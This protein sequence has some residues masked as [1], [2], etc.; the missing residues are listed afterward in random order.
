[1]LLF[2]G[3]YCLSRRLPVRLL[4][5]VWCL[6]SFFLVYFYSSVLISFISASNKVPI[7]EKLT[8]LP[9]KPEV[10]VVT[11]YGWSAD[12]I[13]SVSE[14]FMFDHHQ[15]IYWNMLICRRRNLAFWSIWET[16]WI[17]TLHY[18]VRQLRNALKKS[19]V[20]RSFSYLYVCKY[21]MFEQVTFKRMIR[22]VNQIWI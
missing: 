2:E 10:R 18:D 16:C 11:N 12:A 6:A 5:G 22:S 15:L 9:S 3:N 4:A 21:Q 20:A 7:I 14:F 17:A 19:K 1:L 8:D 13:L